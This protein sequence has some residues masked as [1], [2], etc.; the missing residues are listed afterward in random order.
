MTI[1][2][3]IDIIESAAVETNG[4]AIQ[5]NIEKAETKLEVEEQSADDVKNDCSDG[6]VKPRSQPKQAVISRGLSGEIKWFSHIKRYGFIKTGGYPKELFF[7]ASS[8]IVPYKNYRAHF[9]SIRE[10][11]KVEFD[12]VEGIKGIE[13]TTVSGPDGTQI[14]CYYQ[15]PAG[16]RRPLPP[17]NN[18]RESA[19]DGQEN[20]VGDKQGSG[21]KQ[22]A[23][24]AK[25]K[26]ASDEKDSVGNA[27]K[28][29]RRRNKARRNSKKSVA[30]EEADSKKP[31]EHSTDEDLKGSEEENPK[32]V[33]SPKA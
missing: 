1:P 33:D 14:V 31:A 11:D 8:C 18:P 10:G 4:S 32:T 5:G 24:D 21:G 13:A 30:G 26:E 25:S 23:V 3:T 2:S 29:I 12:I 6:E 7:H 27:R 17:R 9:F 15:R 19:A 16:P 20:T 22:I 28:A